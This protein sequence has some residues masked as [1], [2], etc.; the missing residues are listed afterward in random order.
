MI[1]KLMKDD[2]RTAK[3]VDQKRPYHELSKSGKIKL[4]EKKLEDRDLGLNC[5]S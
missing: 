1:R 5:N 4:S 2:R 3:G